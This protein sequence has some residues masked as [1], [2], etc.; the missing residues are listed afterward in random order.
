[1]DQK[2]TKYGPNMGQIWAKY[3]T[4]YRT[5]MDPELT[6]MKYKIDQNQAQNCTN[7]ISDSNNICTMKKNKAFKKYQQMVQIQKQV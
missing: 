5:K 1:M 3:R 7:I 4:K 6:N 2:W